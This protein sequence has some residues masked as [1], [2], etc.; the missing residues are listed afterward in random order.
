MAVRNDEKRAVRL[1]MKE[2]RARLPAAEGGALG[3]RAG[4]R[5][6][7]LLRFLGARKVGI[8][9]A[10]RGEI[11]LS[12]LWGK[13]RDEKRRY[14]FPRVEGDVLRFCPVRCP[15]REL[16]PGAFGIPEPFRDVPAL[17]VNALDVVVAPGLA[18]APHGARLGSGGGF[19]DRTFQR[20]PDDSDDSRPL[21]VGACYAFQ[22]LVHESFRKDA[23]DVALTG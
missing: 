13:G 20:L 15:D 21:F 9:A 7:V 18:F 22:L 16:Q 1:R 4:R 23:W 2:M 6:D 8:Y 11:D 5:M 3:C 19:Y 10:V 12:S 17:D 14:Y